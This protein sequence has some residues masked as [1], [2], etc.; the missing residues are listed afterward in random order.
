MKRKII[1]K[2][3]SIKKQ[4]VI[5]I[6]IVVILIII[7]YLSIFFRFNKSIYDSQENNILTIMQ[8]IDNS[9]ETNL[10]NSYNKY[11][12]VFN[13]TDFS[14]TE[15]IDDYDLIKGMI[16]IYKDTYSSFSVKDETD[17]ERFE[18]LELYIKKYL[19]ENDYSKYLFYIDQKNNYKN[20]LFL[21]KL[22]ESK[23]NNI[24][25][26]YGILVLD[27]DILIEVFNNIK[28]EHIYIMSI[29]E[30]DIASNTTINSGDLI[31]NEGILLS[32]YSIFHHKINLNNQNLELIAY[33]NNAEL[34]EPILQVV[35]LGIFIGVLG[36]LIISIFFAIMFRSITIPIQNLSK[37]LEKISS[38]DLSIRVNKEVDNELG[39]IADSINEMLENL[40]IT[41]EEKIKSKEE[42]LRLSM[43]QKDTEL[44][45]YQSQINPHFLYNT[46][47]CIKSIGQ[48]YKSVEIEQISI[49]LASIFRYSVKG[50]SEA[51]LAK[52]VETVKNYFTIMDI[53]YPEKFELSIETD[54]MA[55]DFI[56][57]KMIIQPLVENAIMHGLLQKRGKGKIEINAKVEADIF[58]IIIRDTG[59]G[60]EEN[61]LVRIMKSLESSELNA[62]K[63]NS[64]GLN[65][66]VTRLKLNYGEQAQFIINSHEGEGTTI[67]IKIHNT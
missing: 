63:S 26:G 52:E 30:I 10:D 9:I 48:S 8:Q 6:L 23:E 36:L 65:N 44:Q 45:Y 40:E 33:V 27:T 18:N 24:P 38:E 13:E 59:I 12:D 50:G 47:E 35:P 60:I 29:E 67:I 53:R 20:I 42:V 55:A 14:K 62:S 17:I 64:I 39:V 4:F 16:V 57:P 46:L 1:F 43:L 34:K 25:K 28:S 15:L 56:I 37:K 51:T 7:I 31:E 54:P 11:L 41:T 2:N 21:Y 66:I 19:K 3:L 49:S 5:L 32:Q 58:E 61:N 22:P